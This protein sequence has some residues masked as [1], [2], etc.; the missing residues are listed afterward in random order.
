[1]AVDCMEVRVVKDVE[2]GEREHENQNEE[3]NTTI[4]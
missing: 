3:K 4:N 1:V 2:F